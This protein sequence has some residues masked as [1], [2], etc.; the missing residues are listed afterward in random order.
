M[1]A[2]ALQLLDD[3]PLVAR[4]GVVI[5][6]ISPKERIGVAAVPLTFLALTDERRYGSTLLMFY[7]KKEAT[8]VDTT[9]EA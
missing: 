4:T 2:R 7:Q 6:Q 9:T 5:I 3:S 1:A 8:N